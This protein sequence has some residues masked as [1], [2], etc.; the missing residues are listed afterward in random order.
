VSGDLV[1]CA[2]LAA[3][4]EPSLLYD[5]TPSPRRADSILVGEFIDRVHRIFFDSNPLQRT[6]AYEFRLKI[7]RNST[8]YF[9]QIV[10]EGDRL[11]RGEHDCDGMLRNAA[12]CVTMRLG[13]PV[14]EA[15]LR[16]SR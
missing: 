12:Q 15:M 16:A 6:L 8:F 2:S 5:Q 10:L 11:H 9:R 13:M 1:E 3:N 7:A 4:V 14:T